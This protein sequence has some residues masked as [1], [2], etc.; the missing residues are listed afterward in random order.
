MKIAVISSYAPSLLNFRGP[1][2]RDLITAGHQVSVGG[3]D[4]DADVRARIEALG[5]VVHETPLNRNGTGILADLRYYH[6]LRRL[7]LREKPD[8]VLTYTIKPN[9]WGAFAAAAARI[10]SFALVTGLGYAF[11]ETGKRPTLKKRLAGMVAR[12]LYRAATDRNQQVIFQ[13]SDDLRDFIA[14]GCLA[15]PDKASIIAGSGVDMNHYARLPLPETPVVLMIARLLRTKGVAD[16]AEAALTIRKSHPQAR[17]L[18]VGPF[19]GGPDSITEAELDQW[20]ADGLEYLGSRDDV[21]EA[22][23]EARIYVLPSYREGTPRSVLEAMA[24]GRPVITTDV[25]GCRETVE[26]GVNGFLVPVR[27]PVALAKAI[28]QLLDDPHQAER[29][30]D[31]GYN[32]VA[33]KF[34]VHLVNRQIMEILG[35][36]S[37]GEET[38]E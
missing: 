35:L 4:I 26:N 14:A 17:F 24:M 6:T 31:A 10:S 11:T 13:N 18:L 28:S 22:L 23:A 8:L 9:I 7:M 12:R 34:D 33:R 1:L 2:I 5:A 20:V 38:H 29:M 37:T 32:L 3:P 15:D 30:G 25:P 36:R 19:D 21:R 16:Y 27:N